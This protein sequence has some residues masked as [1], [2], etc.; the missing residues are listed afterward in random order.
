MEDIE[1]LISGL[2]IL[3]EG[4]KIMNGLKSKS[5]ICFIVVLFLVIFAGILIA[6]NFGNWI[7]YLKPEFKGK[8]IDAETREPVEGAV[9]MVAYKREQLA[10]PHSTSMLKNIR[11]AVTKEDGTFIV[12]AYTSVA[13]PLSFDFYVRFL[14]YKPGYGRFPGQKAYPLGLTITDEETFFSKET[15][16]KGEIVMR[17][18]LDET[19]ISERKKVSVEFGI[20]ELQKLKTREER[21]KA[22]PSPE[23][24][25]RSD[26]KKQRNLIKALR[27][28]RQY[29][30]S[31]DASDLYSWE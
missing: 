23:G 15:G 29:L 30:F 3:Y 5:A 28:E 20:V 26:Y 18:K 13:G 1:A 22:K 2:K 8:V 17:V 19:G 31:E 7:I 6:L 4:L 14:I 21:I 11:E 9:V 25:K 24:W 10:I 16:G 27:G 12:P